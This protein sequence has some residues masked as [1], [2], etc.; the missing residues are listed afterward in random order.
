MKSFLILYNQININF[1]DTNLTKNFFYVHNYWSI[2]YNKETLN[3]N[4]KSKILDYALWYNFIEELKQNWYNWEFIVWKSFYSEIYKYSKQYNLTEIF[5]VKPNENYVYENFL[6]IKKKL[7]KDNIKLI[8]LDDRVSFLLDKKK[9][10]KEFQKFPIM[11]T[12][13]RFMR[14]E[15]NIL[16][17]DWKPIWWKWNY[18][19]ENRGFDKNHI[20]TWNINFEENIWIKKAKLFY[21]FEGTINY[22]STREQS[23]RLLNY[24]ISNH[25]NNF[26]ILEDAMYEWDDF[27]NHSLISTALNFWLL[28]PLELIR[29]IEKQDTDL[30]NKEW[31]IRQVLWWREYIYQFFQHYKDEIYINNFFSHKNN[32][33]DF[34]WWKDLD[35]CKMNCLKKVIK[36]VLKNNYSHHIERLMII[37]NFCLLIWV[38]PFELNKWFFEK[39]TDAFEWV[40]SPNVLW[41]SQYS[42][43]WKIATKPY[44]SS[45]NY[46]NKMSDFCKNCS[47]NVKT[48]YEND[49]CPFNYLYWNFVYENKKTF[50]NIRQSYIL[51]NLENIDINKIKQAKHNFLSSKYSR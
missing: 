39:Y 28:N 46:I 19:K 13:Y 6:K 35:K 20:K 9:F 22:P 17:I 47:Y 2:Y 41:M 12:F 29:L 1:F 32:L 34:F 26:W 43:W 23:L 11:E 38:N 24:F 33:P 44:I 42:D 45:W 15:Y 3:L 49:S 30:N 27:V 31:F 50:Q 36:R 21:K 40:V 8:F 5:L 4:K 18:D 37:W 51:K 16:L 25:L 14:K 48:K 10:D 7:E